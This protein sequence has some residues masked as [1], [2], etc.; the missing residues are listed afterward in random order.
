MKGRKRTEKCKLCKKKKKKIK[1]IIFRLFWVVAFLLSFGAC[2]FLIAKIYIKWRNDP[3]VV[4]LDERSSPTWLIPFPAITICPESKAAKDFLDISEVFNRTR[5]N[6]SISNEEEIILESLYQVCDFFD[7]GMWKLDPRVGNNTP[8]DYIEELR[9]VSIGYDKVST[10]E[11][12]GNR[13]S[14]KSLFHETVT[15][16]GIC[17]T[18]NMMDHQDMYRR[19]LDPSLKFPKHGHRSDWTLCGYKSFE[20]QTYPHRVLGSG[21]RAGLVIVLM[22]NT[23][24]IDYACKYGVNGYRYF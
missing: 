15:D 17:H 7:G 10:V 18:F 4:I 22:M 13:S 12:K 24:D 20:A 19:A 2:T 8:V 5:H 11:W 21:R 6:Y 9:K 3:V 1:I 16:E 23:S 14:F